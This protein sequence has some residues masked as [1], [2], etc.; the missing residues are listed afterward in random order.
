MPDRNKT[1]FSWNLRKYREGDEL[2]IV[3]LL[4]TVFRNWKSLEYWKWWHKDNPAGSPIIC[5]AEYN[6]KI[7]G[8]YGIV[9]MKMK[10]GNTYL[11]GSVGCDAATHPEYQGKGIFSYVINKCY[12][13]AAENNIPLTYGL[14][15]INLGPTYKRYEWRG[16]ICLRINMIKVLNWEPLLSRYIHNKFLIRVAA[17]FLG[18]I[19]RSNSEI[20]IE[21]EIKRIRYFDERFNI[22]WEDISK[23][24]K[25]I[26]KRDQTFL[27]WRY[28]DHPVN[29]YTIFM[30]VKDDSIFGYC[31]LREERKENLRRGQIVDILG[32]QNH[33]NVIG[34]LIQRALKHFKEKDID[35]ISC[36][37]SEKNP[38]KEIFKKAGFTSYPRHKTALVATINLQGS[39]IDEKAVYDQALIFSQNWFLKEKKNWFIMSGDGDLG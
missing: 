7:I 30:A 39:I 4:N 34:Y 36:H 25:I 11:T 29:K 13:D 24:F 5:L 23:Q 14:A 6:N 2:S 20:N 1:N 21:L 32:L 35:Y 33:Y 37:M 27:N 12:Q 3:D 22:F 31:I 10:V 8:H 26:V 15:N 19:Y 9:P 18:K 16:H 28:V 17:Y 38:Y